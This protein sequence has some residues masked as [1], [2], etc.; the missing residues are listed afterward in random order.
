VNVFL[1]LKCE[2]LCILHVLHCE[3][4]QFWVAKQLPY[5]HAPEPLALLW[6][7]VVRASTTRT[8]TGPITTRHLKFDDF[9]MKPF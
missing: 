3:S 1:L 8:M 7:V 6:V 4:D 2:S 5:S 9:F